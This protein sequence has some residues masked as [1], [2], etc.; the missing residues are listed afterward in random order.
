MA[1]QEHQCPRCGAAV[2]HQDAGIVHCAYCATPLEP[3]RDGFRVSS[4]FAEDN[5][6]D[7]GRPRF[8][9]AGSRYRMLG[10]LAA[11]E[12]SDVFLAQR[13]H[14]LS[15]RVI[16]KVLR[17]QED[18]DLFDGEW[19]TLS[20]LQTSTARGSAH[21]TRLLPQPV[22]HGEGR[23]GVRGNEGL[24]LLSIFAFAS[25]FVHA[26]DDVRGTYPRGVPG[27]AAVWLWKRTL[28]LLAF[29]HESGWVHG[30][31]LPRHLLV[32]ARD[33]GVRLCGWSSATNLGKALPAV[34][35]N[36]EAFYPEAIW[37]G[38]RASAATDISMSARSMLWLL[39]GTPRKAVGNT[40]PALA[41]LMEKYAEADAGGFGDA[42]AVI[43]ALT[44][45]AEE[46]Y[47]PPKFVPFAMPGWNIAAN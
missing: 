46:A 29:V 8:W 45:A 2:P 7:P 4:L 17:A 12:T 13:D 41:Q 20:A 37:R 24:R 1:Y 25:G 34:P 33:H 14:R 38:G 28:E 39:G 23:L 3:T 40:P 42:R 15:E 32:H 31:V 10:L 19:K 30:A 5:L 36:D 16:V 6:V 11:G 9:L 44:A 27:N 43:A 18:R 35:A 47:G 21:F 26:F 22:A